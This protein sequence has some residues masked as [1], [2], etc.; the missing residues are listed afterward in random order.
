MNPPLLLLARFGRSKGR[1]EGKSK[2]W[3]YQKKSFRALIPRPPMLFFTKSAQ[4]WPS[5]ENCYCSVAQQSRVRQQCGF[6]FNVFKLQEKKVMR[7]LEFLFCL[8]SNF[9]MGKQ[10]FLSLYAQQFSQEGIH[11]YFLVLSIIVFVIH[12]QMLILDPN[13]YVHSFLCFLAF[14]EII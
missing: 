8:S 12:A 7:Y 2:F 1:Q 10:K 4:N 11:I 14:Y 6:G 9:S 3:T 13:L 5:K